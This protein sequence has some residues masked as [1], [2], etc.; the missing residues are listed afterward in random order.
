MISVWERRRAR[1]HVQKVIREAYW[2]HI[3]NFFSFDTDTADPDCPRKNEVKKIR[4]FVKSIKKDAS[5]ITTLRENGILKTDTLD[6][7][8]ICNKKFQSAFTRESDAEIPSKGTSSFT[9]IG[10]IT[11]DPKGILKLLNNLKIHKASGPDGLSAMVLKECSYE[12]APLLA[13]IYNESLDQ[14]TR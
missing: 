5:G 14:G 12:I 1:A 9:P 2:K 13:L 10:E 7:V 6:R 4:S 11:V 8:N 3:S